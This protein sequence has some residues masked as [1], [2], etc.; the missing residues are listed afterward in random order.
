MN[1]TL[2]NFTSIVL[3]SVLTVFL[4]GCGQK[5]TEKVGTSKEFSIGCMPLNEPAVR[6]ISEMMKMKG[7]DMK[8]VVFDGNTL[9]AI[10]LKDKSI[11]GLILNHLPWINTFNAKHNS[12]LVMVK[13]YIY[14]SLFGIYSSKHKSVDEIPDNATITISNDP[15]NMQRSLLLA[16]KY[17]LIKLG[18]KKGKFFTTL[19]ISENPKN[20]KFSEI[21][22]TSTASS[23]K[24]VDA[25]IGFSSV[26]RNAGIDAKSYIVED[27]QSV[28]FPTGLVVNGENQ[29]A[30]WI[31]A[32]SEVV[33]ADEFKKRF[34]DSFKGAYVLFP[35]L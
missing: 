1:K 28:N 8:V 19:D 18:E 10:A 20:I 13:P 26:M 11:D 32:I 34:N 33:K 9:P 25:T 35:S 24:D 4:A 7:Y 23:Y 16:E 2:R 29:N 5:T 31:N 17:G 22:T 21:E 6:A 27:G 14:A 15:D 30:D 3:A 12:N